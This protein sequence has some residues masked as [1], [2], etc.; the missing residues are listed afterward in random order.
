MRKNLFSSLLHKPATTWTIA[1]A[2]ALGTLSLVGCGGA[3]AFGDTFPDNREDH[4]ALVTQRLEAGREASLRVS[5]EQAVLVAVS[6]APMRLIAQDLER[7]T[8]LWETPVELRTVPYVAGHFVVTH[9]GSEVVIRSLQTGRITGRVAD[10]SLNLVGAAGEGD[11]GVVVLST[12]GGVSAFSVVVGLSAGAPTFQAEM[13]Q[14][15]GAP[16]VSAGMAFVPWGHQNISVVDLGSGGEIAR[17]RATDGVVAS[18]VARDGHVFFGQ[19]GVALLSTNTA[20]AFLSIQGEMPG[21]PALLRDAYQPPPGPNS[22][23]SRVRLV[24]RLADRAGAAAFDQDSAYL[25]YYRLVIALN[26]DGQSARWIAQ[27]PRDAVGAE[28]VDAGLLVTDESGAVHLL[29]TAD[30][31]ETRAVLLG[32]GVISSVAQADAL[33]GGAPAGE[34]MHLRDQLLAAAQNTDARLVPLRELAVRL[35]AALPE[36]EV[37]GNLI[38][39]CEEPAT[40]AS[41]RREACR[42]LA[43]RTSGNDQVLHALEQHASFLRGIHAPPVGA[44]AQASLAMNE[45]RAVPLLLAHLRDPETAAADIAPLARALGSF[46]E[47][48]AAE[49]LADFIRL[50]HAETVEAGLNEGLLASLTAYRTLLGPTSREFLDEMVAD[51]LTPSTIRDAAQ[52]ELAALDAPQVEATATTEEAPAADMTLTEADDPRPPTL[53]PQLV[54]RILDDARPELEACLRTPRR[55]VDLV[56][57]VMVAEPTGNVLMV[58]TTPTEAQACV[59]PIVRAHTYPATRARGRQTVTVEV[60]R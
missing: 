38:A 16:A 25:V 52:A 43:T 7:G 15:L 47:S 53:T 54:N 5:H 32:T 48:S 31:R 50:Y 28:V 22:A 56:R 30:G 14:P 24:T 20:P 44:L 9:E 21:N 33:T 10:R 36:P 4:L 41:V 51:A 39:I 8:Q 13:Q 42:V 27:L 3:V 11:Q 2:L 59:E 60:R 55:V 19:D 29:S 58:T 46:G 35:L 12:G 26:A 23:Q 6:A 1:G 37:T 45:R 49:P 40:T 57:I 18:A 17:L 34:P